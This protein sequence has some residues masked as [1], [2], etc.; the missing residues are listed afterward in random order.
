[1]FQHGLSQVSGSG[2]IGSTIE[3]LAASLLF[4]V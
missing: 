2:L 4:E 3:S 1:M